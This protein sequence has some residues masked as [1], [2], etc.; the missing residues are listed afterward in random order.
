MIQAIAETPTTQDQLCPPGQ[1]EIPWKNPGGNKYADTPEKAMQTRESAFRRLGLP[2]EVVQ[3]ALAETQ[4]P[5]EDHTILNGDRMIAMVSGSGVMHC[6]YADFKVPQKGMQQGAP[7]KMWRVPSKGLIYVILRP[8]ICNNWTYFIEQDPCFVIAFST[9]PRN[10][11]RVRNVRW[12]IG[13]GSPEPLPPSECTAR[14][15]G[16]DPWGGLL[17][18]CDTCVVPVEA[19]TFIERLLGRQVL[20]YYTY[21]YPVTDEWQE[22]RFP[23]S[24]QNKAVRICLEYEDNT[25]TCGVYVSRKDWD[26]QS[27]VTIPDDM[28][29]MDNGDCP[30]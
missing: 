20:A 16:A 12:G 22:L 19:L 25:A 30:K 7:A 5:G 11:A 8:D 9:H 24:M 15:Q 26:G 1:K 13:S 27:V 18:P 23:R 28:W 14:H 4:K 17:D 2:E 10:G 3:L 21:M 29:L 6:L